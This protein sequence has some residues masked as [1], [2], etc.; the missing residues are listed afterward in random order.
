M[1]ACPMESRSAADVAMSLVALELGMGPKE[2]CNRVSS[3]A[4]SV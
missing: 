4:G 3:Q 1:V 2:E